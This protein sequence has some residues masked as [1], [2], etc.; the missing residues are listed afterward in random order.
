[1]WLPYVVG[2]T[3]LDALTDVASDHVIATEEEPQDEEACLCGDPSPQ[4]KGR[5]PRKDPLLLAKLGLGDIDAKL[6][7]E[8]DL[9]CSCVAMFWISVLIWQWSDWSVLPTSDATYLLAVIAGVAYAC[10]MRSVMK[11]WELV[12]STIVTPMMQLSGPVV[13]IF[14]AALGAVAR[15]RRRP[16]ILDSVANA[17]LAP[18][19]AVAF[20]LITL[21]GLA[22]STDSLPQLA[23]WSTWRS[24]AMSL[25]LVSNLLYATYYILLSLCVGEKDAPTPM[26]EL[27][28]VVISNL[29]AVATLTLWFAANP[30]LRRH[31]RGLANV[32]KFPK[33]VSAAAEATNYAAMLLLSFA[34]QRHYSSG[35]VTAARTGLNQFTNVILAAVLYTLGGIGRP[36][37][38]FNKKILAACLVSIG[39]FISVDNDDDDV[40]PIPRILEPRQRPRPRLGGR[41]APRVPVGSPV[42]PRIEVGRLLQGSLGFGATALRLEAC[43]QTRVALGESRFERHHS[44]G[45]VQCFVPPAELLQRR[46][47]VRVAEVELLLLLPAGDRRRKLADA[48]R[49]GNTPIN[50]SCS[51]TLDPTDLRAETVVIASSKFL[52]DE[53]WLNGER[54]AREGTHAKR[55]RECLSLM[56]E[57]CELPVTSAAASAAEL[58]AWKVRVVSRNNFPTA[59][60]LASSAAGYAALVTALAKLYGVRGDLSGVARI[61][62]GSACRSLDGGLVAWRKGSSVDGADSIA[63]P[64]VGASHWPELRV[65]IVV[66]DASEKETPSTEGMQRSVETSPFLS[67]R[68]I[69]VAEPRIDELRDAFSSRDFDRFAEI[70]MRDSNSFHATCLDTYPPIF[71]MNETSRKVVRAVHALND[72]FPQAQA[73]YTFDAGPNAVVFCKTPEAS[74]MLLALLKEV[75]PKFPVVGPER[76]RDPPSSLLPPGLVAKVG[77]SRGTTTS[78]SVVKLVYLTKVGAGAGS[79]LPDAALAD[80]VDPSTLEPVLEPRFDLKLGNYAARAEVKVDRLRH[81]YFQ[82]GPERLDV[83]LEHRLALITS[84]STTARFPSPPK[85]PRADT[86]ASALASAFGGALTRAYTIPGRDTL[87]VALRLA[88]AKQL[89]DTVPPENV[90]REPHYLLRDFY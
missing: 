64:L 24:P 39:L 66:A 49:G 83:H 58:K 29:A 30:D 88:I 19:D 48:A 31:A 35:L 54:A 89:I 37:R 70:C 27:H 28:F 10:A 46:A 68:A 14:E 75:F 17:Q 51:L 67:Y 36:V 21:G 7:S 26:T 16:S 5:K 59:A 61:G 81:V 76:D 4:A 90:M 60:G 62:S 38:D 44:L 40:E 9:V 74:Q 47:P 18:T 34:Y 56:R 33:L 11:A 53:L 12:P 6:T 1:M 69:N 63:E 32:P 2:A 87:T 55:L 23:R 65:V 25:L 57:R 71:Y 84:F 45:V 52:E 72:A 77:R 8:Q 43:P 80:L 13:E 22:P 82:P 73:A 20:A 86:I 85:S 78:S 41:L 42:G 79:P 50:S 3:V 15:R